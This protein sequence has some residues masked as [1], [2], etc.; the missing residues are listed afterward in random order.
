MKILIVATTKQSYG[1]NNY[2][3]NNNK[4]KDRDIKDDRVR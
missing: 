1:I 4:D 2:N 3:N